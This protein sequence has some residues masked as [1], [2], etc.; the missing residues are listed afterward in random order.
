MADDP[1]YDIRVRRTRWSSSDLDDLDAAGIVA[2]LAPVDVTAV[3]TSEEDGNRP[4]Y[5]VHGIAAAVY[6]DEGRAV[7]RWSSSELTS[8][9]ER[10]IEAMRRV[11]AR[12]QR[13]ADL[14]NAL[15][16]GVD[17]ADVLGLPRTVDQVVDEVAG[18]LQDMWNLAEC[19]EATAP[20]LDLNRARQL[21]RAAMV[22][23]ALIRDRD[24]MNPLF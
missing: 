5:C 10:E 15:A 4:G 3:Y 22:R 23:L 7:V 11:L 17:P 19:S 18:Y 21:A 24:D 8:A 2:A 6:A 9:G 14:A 13:I 16:R 20:T 12:A 1:L